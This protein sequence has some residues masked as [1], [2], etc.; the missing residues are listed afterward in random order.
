VNKQSA[1][2]VKEFCQIWNRDAEGR[3]TVIFVPGHNGHRYGVRI[4]R[5]GNIGVQCFRQDVQN[6]ECKGNSNGHICYHALA[7]LEF[8]AEDQGLTLSWCE[9][10]QDA[11]RLARI[12]GKVFHAKSLQSDAEVWGVVKGGEQQAFDLL[13]WA[14]ELENTVGWYDAELAKSLAT[15]GADTPAQL[16]KLH[17]LFTKHPERKSDLLAIFSEAVLAH[18][19][20]VLRGENVKEI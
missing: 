5:N 4:K 2:H 14:D 16:N 11:E 6:V 12:E 10:E 1:R 20:G 17:Q 9:S 8:A 15:R 3:P 19:R 18:G 13:A 7:A